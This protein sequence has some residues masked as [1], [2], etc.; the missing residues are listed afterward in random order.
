MINSFVMW[1]EWIDARQAIA[2]LTAER[3]AARAERDTLLIR[4]EAAEANYRFHFDM[5]A[6]DDAWRRAKRER[7]VRDGR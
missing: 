3:D 1:L 4:L 5:T 7:A 2:T 6:A